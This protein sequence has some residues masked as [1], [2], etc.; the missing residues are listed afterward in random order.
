MPRPRND[1]ELIRE[2]DR[3]ITALERPTV[4]RVGPWTLT[5]D[6]NGNL[7]ATNTATGQSGVVTIGGVSA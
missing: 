3:R 7:T 5:A 4:L 6:D 1:Q 2:F